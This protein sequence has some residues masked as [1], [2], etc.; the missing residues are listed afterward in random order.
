MTEFEMQVLKEL[1][2]MNSVLCVIGILLVFILI[3]MARIK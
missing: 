2:S 1:A 3:D